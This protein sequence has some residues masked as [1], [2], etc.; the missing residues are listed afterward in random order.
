MR[1]NEAAQTRILSLSR[2]FPRVWNDPRTEPR[3]RKRLLAL[4]IEDVTLLKADTIAVH[5]RFRGGQTTS[6]SLPRPVPISQVRKMKPQLLAALDELLDSYTDQE[7]ADKPNA[8]QY[9]NWRGQQFTRQKVISVRFA[10]KIKS[11]YQ[12]LRERGL[13]PAQTLAQRFGV[14]LCVI[15]AWGRAGWLPRQHYD[16]HRSLYEPVHSVRIRKISPGRGQH[17]P[18]SFITVQSLKQ[19]TV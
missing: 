3:E 10:H 4:L 12:H 7:A 6:L 11:R 13:L 14:S 19:E 5:V 15:H 16:N 9:R 2:D 18:A 1:V 8:L 17:R